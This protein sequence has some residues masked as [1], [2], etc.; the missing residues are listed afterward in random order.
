MEFL[1][2]TTYRKNNYYQLVTNCSCEYF[3]KIVTLRASI[4]ARIFHGLNAYPPCVTRPSLSHQVLS[5]G[6]IY[7]VS[8][9]SL[10]NDI[11]MPGN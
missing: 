5:L 9:E 7:R 10:R 1:L 3:G 11:V 6:T 8:N 2:S 4:V